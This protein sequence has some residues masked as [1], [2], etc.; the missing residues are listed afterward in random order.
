MPTN[1]NDF[2]LPTELHGSSF[3]DLGCWEGDVCMEA[4][5]R[6]ASRA[7]GVDLSTSP[8]LAET[9][10]K[11]P[12]IEFVL[13][14]V[15]SE[16][17]SQLGR[18]DIVRCGGLLYHLADP[19]RFLSRLPGVL[20]E[21]GTLSLETTCFVGAGDLPVA[22]FHPGTSL[23]GDPSNW[24]SL[25]ESMLTEL[26]QEYGF[27]EIRVV[28]RRPSHPLNPETPHDHLVGRI[29]V[30]AQLG[31]LRNRNRRKFAPRRPTFM[32]LGTTGGSRREPR[33]RGE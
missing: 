25:S 4:I 33:S 21:G 3:L 31:T 9:L 28:N 23:R 10:T 17:F 8:E 16:R 22:L 12:S 18:F 19:I 1:W 32:P 20:A 29:T 15:E 27:V 13:M 26:L 6:G 11:V 2:G 14:D 5:Q 30:V 7:V 24:F